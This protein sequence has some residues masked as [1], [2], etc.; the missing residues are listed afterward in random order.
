MQRPKEEIRQKIEQAALAEFL[1]HGFKQASL[2]EIANQSDITV[3]NIYA[4]FK[5]K[6]D[7]F[8]QIISPAL[9]EMQQFLEKI[10]KEQT[11]TEPSLTLI[12]AETTQIFLR[13]RVQF[14]ILMTASSGTKYEH[15]KDDFIQMV[16]LRL[17]QELFCTLPAELQQE[18]LIESFAYAIVSGLL[19]IFQQAQPNPQQT[20]ET[21]RQFMILILH[22]IYPNTEKGE[23]I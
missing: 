4:Y 18:L 16:A 8:D 9:R 1:E 17:R 3:G 15:V 14:L 11:I 13:Y 10:G 22:N 21:I 5:S 12:A 2:R 19:H 20:Q 23:A 7:L 6:D